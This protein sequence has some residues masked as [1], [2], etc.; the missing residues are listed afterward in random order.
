MEKVPLVQAIVKQ[1]PWGRVEKDGTFPEDF[2]YALFGV[3]GHEGFGYWSTP[4]GSAP[5]MESSDAIGPVDVT[6]LKVPAQQGYQHGYMLLHKEHLDEKE[7]WK[8]EERLIPKLHFDPGTEPAIASSVEITDWKSWHQ[9]RNLPM[10]SPASLLMHYPLTVYQLLVH[11]L[12]VTHPSRNSAERRQMLNIHYPGPEIELNMLPLFSELALL[13]PYTDIRLTFYGAAVYNIVKQAKKG[14]LAMKAKRN[15]PVYT[16]KSPSSMGGGTVAIYLHGEH[17]NWDPRIPSLTNNNP[18]AMVSANAGLVNYKAWQGVIL[19]C[20]VEKIPFAVTEYAEQSAEVQ[21]DSI[22]QILHHYAS[23]FLHGNL[24]TD[25]LQTLLSPRSYPIEF[26]PFQRPGQRYIGSTRLPNVS[27]GFTIRVVG[28]GSDE[29][30]GD[31][32]PPHSL[33]TLDS[34][35]EIQDLVERAKNISLNGLD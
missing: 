17:E 1:F 33:V 19:Y 32:S 30:T 24:T 8:I 23:S 5:H 2:I 13:L 7:A 11:V 26:N 35:S 9:W 10:E 34:T 3:L 15:E 20:H 16:Y 27:N 22:P 21:V 18:D 6:P 31:V 29:T 4:G 14:S 28:S 25:A 12:H